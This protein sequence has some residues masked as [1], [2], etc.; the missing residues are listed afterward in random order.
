MLINI[1]AT[2]DDLGVFF[3]VSCLF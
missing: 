3:Q 1:Q 2:I